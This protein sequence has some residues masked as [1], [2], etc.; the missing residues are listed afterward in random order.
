M[1]YD[2]STTATKAPTYGGMLCQASE[3]YVLN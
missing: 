2:T 3:F 1:K